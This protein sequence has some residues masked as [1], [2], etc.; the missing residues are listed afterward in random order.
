M[1]ENVKVNEFWKSA[2]PINY[3]DLLNNIKFQNAIVSN[4]FY[5]NYMISEYHRQ[6]QN[7]LEVISDIEK[8]VEEE[9]Q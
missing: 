2:E 4:I 8:Y 1:I 5:R 7:V 9:G 6:K 3:R